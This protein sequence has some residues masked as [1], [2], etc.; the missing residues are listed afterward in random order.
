MSLLS[1]SVVLGLLAVGN[2]M[3]ASPASAP[4]PT[5]SVFPSGFDI[6]SSWANLAPLKEPSGFNVS[7]GVP[8]GCELSQAHVLHRHAQRYP[9]S[10]KLDGGGI[11]KFSE[12]LANY[13]RAHNTTDIAS[14]PLSFL[15]DWDYLLG[16][17]TLLP[18][19]AA[20]EA[21]SGANVWSKYGRFLYRAGPGVERWNESLNV[22]PNGTDR[23]KPIFRTT[24]QGRILE[25]ARWWLSGFFDNEGANS[26]YSEYDLVVIPEGSGYNNTLGSDHSCENSP[27]G[28]NDDGAAFINIFAQDAVARLSKFLPSDFNLTAFDV[29]SMMVLCPYEYATMRRSSFC[30]LFTEQE[31]I[32]YAYGIDIQFYGVFGPGSPTGRAQGIGYLLELAARLQGQT[33]SSSDTSI[34]ATWDQSPE[35]FPLNQPLYMDMS[36]DTVIVAILAAL[37]LK[38]FNYGPHGLP[39]NVPHSVERNFHLNEVTPFGANIVTEVWTCPAEA[40]FETLAGAMYTNP[41]LSDTAGT[42]DYLRFVLNGAPIPLDGMVGCEDAVNG[43]CAVEGFLEGVP[44]LKEN[45]MYQYACFG[46]YDLGKQV[47]DGHP[48]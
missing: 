28:G 41:D 32:D 37:G 46:D 16:K 5:G 19:G 14:G 43:F 11:D 18:T 20:T 24:T 15:N 30:S 36:H 13:S 9:T 29:A 8:R 3:P 4:A 47:G 2:A 26:S 42:K 12:K 35:T 48:E 38:Y 1:S 6:V 34:N 25:S 27:S 7:K 17:D 23:P 44:T 39:W 45:A 22:Y 31:W 10:F 21:T 40:S 33:I